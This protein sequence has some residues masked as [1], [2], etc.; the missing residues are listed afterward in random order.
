LRETRKPL[1]RVNAQPAY[2]VNELAAKI[3]NAIGGSPV[4][5]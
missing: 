2:N 5:Q 1:L 4:P 3:R